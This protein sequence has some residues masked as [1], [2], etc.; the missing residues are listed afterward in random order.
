MDSKYS[1]GWSEGKEFLASGKPDTLKGSFYAN[2]LVDDQLQPSSSDWLQ[3]WA[4][5]P[6]A[7]RLVGEL[8]PAYGSSYNADTK[9]VC[10][11]GAAV[12]DR[13]ESEILELRRRHPEYFRKNLWPRDELPEM[14][15]AIK[16][17]GRLICAVGCLLAEHC[18]R[19][20]HLRVGCTFDYAPRLPWA[21]HA[22]PP[23]RMCVGN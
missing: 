20:V 13:T 18:D 19:H 11:A 17:L 15:L 16:D 8:S 22:V 10:V 7:A 14:E 6:A 12:L 4:F 3:P 5:Q 2:P 1:Y 23:M 9:S 21:I